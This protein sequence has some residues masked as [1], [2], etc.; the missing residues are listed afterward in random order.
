MCIDACC[1]HA[2]MQAS[3]KAGSQPAVHSC[4]CVYDYDVC[5]Y[6][7][8]NACTY[9]YVRP[10]VH[11]WV[12][13]YIYIYM[14]VMICIHKYTHKEGVERDTKTQQITNIWSCHACN[15]KNDTTQFNAMNCMQCHALQSTTCVSACTHVDADLLPLTCGLFVAMDNIWS[16]P[17][18]RLM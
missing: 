2:S 6:V 4:M 17:D 7:C 9:V 18:P 12:C 13:L 8:I 14:Y 15:A 3:R 16:W 11:V 5:M 10:R 1:M